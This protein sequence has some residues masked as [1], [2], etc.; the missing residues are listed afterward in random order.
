MKRYLLWNVKC[1]AIL[2]DVFSFLTVTVFQEAL[3]GH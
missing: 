3:Q 2:K 1:G